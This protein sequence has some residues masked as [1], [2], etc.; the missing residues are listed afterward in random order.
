MSL[1]GFYLLGFISA[2]VLGWV[3]G[4][5]WGIH[6]TRIQYLRKFKLLNGQIKGF[7]K[8]GGELL[9]LTIRSLDS[10]DKDTLRTIRSFRSLLT[11]A[12]KYTA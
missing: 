8:A 7:K 12:E 4:R 11:W 1:V 5:L 3:I 10:I 6:K 9:S 2:L